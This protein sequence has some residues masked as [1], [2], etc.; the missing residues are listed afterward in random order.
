MKNFLLFLKTTVIG[1]IVFL[2]PLVILGVI[3]GQAFAVARGI[4][5][6][7]M[8]RLP[9]KSV[10]GIALI[11]LLAVAI[12]VLFCFLMGLVARTALARRGVGWLERT[13][14]T[15]IPGYQFMKN[16]RQNMLGVK[17]GRQYPPVLARVEG[18]WQ[19]G[20]Q[21]DQTASGRVSVFVPNAPNTWTGRIFF[22]EE[23]SLE[24]LDIRPAQAL[25]YIECLGE[26]EP[27]SI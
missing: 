16:M 21:L 9:A 5:V 10:G 27:V 23:A 24:R 14:L 4:L 17:S 18:G 25:G 20:F 12:L 11:S 13:C 6:P 8:E 2:V 19:L 22:V 15:P 3:V 1:G 26:G 7:L